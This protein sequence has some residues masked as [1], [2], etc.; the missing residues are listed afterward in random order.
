MKKEG[1]QEEIRLQRE[2]IQRIE[3]ASN[4]RCTFVF[5]MHH[6]TPGSKSKPKTILSQMKAAIMAV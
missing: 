4:A 5:A 1:N 2:K 3:V 6:K